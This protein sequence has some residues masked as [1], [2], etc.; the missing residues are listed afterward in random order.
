MT[1]F[2]NKLA[3]TLEEPKP[4]AG[5]SRVAGSVL[6]GAVAGRAQRIE[7]IREKAAAGARIHL[8]GLDHTLALNL[9]PPRRNRRPASGCAWKELLQ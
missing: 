7:A 2:Q 1:M 5:G 6:H 3:H 4:H 9:P 8:P